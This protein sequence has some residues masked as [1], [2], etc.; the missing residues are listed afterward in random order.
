MASTCKLVSSTSGAATFLRLKTCIWRIKQCF[1]GNWF[2]NT[3]L[4]R[5]QVSD[6]SNKN[7]KCLINVDT[8]KSSYYFMESKNKYWSPQ[9]TADEK[10]LI[11]GTEK[12]EMSHMLALLEDITFL[13]KLYWRA[14]CWKKAILWSGVWLVVCQ[15]SIKWS[16]NWNVVQITSSDGWTA[17]GIKTYF[18]GGWNGQT[19]V[20][21]LSVGDK[22]SM[23]ASC[24]GHLLSLS[25]TQFHNTHIQLWPFFHW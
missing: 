8:L 15:D 14:K 3:V 10:E 11:E 7:I 20:V 4:Q 12:R 17:V 22:T 25:E 6:I 21:L 18:L 23:T 2:T 19:D 5:R 1:T 13:W 24:K 9:E 16:M